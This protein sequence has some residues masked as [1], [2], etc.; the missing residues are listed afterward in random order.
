MQCKYCHKELSKG[1]WVL[2]QGAYFH[3]NCVEEYKKEKRKKLQLVEQMN[4]VG[5]CDFCNK[6]FE[7]GSWAVYHTDGKAYHSKCRDIVIDKEMKEQKKQEERAQKENSYVYLEPK[8]P[9]MSELVRE[10]LI[11]TIGL[12]KKASNATGKIFRDA[13]MRAGK[14]QK[15]DTEELAYSIAYEE[16][17]TGKFSKG[18][19]AKAIAVTEG[20][21]KKT[22][23]KY[24]QLRAAQLI[25]L[26]K[27][28]Q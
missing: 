28:I 13:E 4:E 7:P 14:Y 23:A 22:K 6:G 1:E 27:D 24:I 10:G 21:D 15:I 17:E 5:N 11:N 19:M 8:G 16:V 20:S 25:E 2:H 3:E 26:A 18:I 9:P 12:F